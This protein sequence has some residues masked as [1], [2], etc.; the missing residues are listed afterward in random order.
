VHSVEG[1]AYRI[2]QLLENPELAKRMGE[3]GR[4]HIRR[5]FITTKNIRNY[6]GFWTALEKRE[7][8]IYV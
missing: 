8:V 1:A 4:E 7:Q 3:A 2:R 6:L 5:N